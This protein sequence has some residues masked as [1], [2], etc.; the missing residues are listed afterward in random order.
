MKREVVQLTVVSAAVV[1]LYYYV[2]SHGGGYLGNTA[3]T[4]V[5]L[6]IFKEW[7]QVFYRLGLKSGRTHSRAEG[8]R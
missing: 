2:L 7:S 3:V 4:A 8:D 5:A 1:C 6:Y